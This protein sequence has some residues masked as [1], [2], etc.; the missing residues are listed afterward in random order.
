MTSSTRDNEQRQAHLM[1]EADLAARWKVS[2]RTIQRWRQDGRLPVA[3][4][5][6]RKIL[7]NTESVVEFEAMPPASRETYDG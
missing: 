5:I 3:F 6:G 2:K 7:F 1:T 4:R